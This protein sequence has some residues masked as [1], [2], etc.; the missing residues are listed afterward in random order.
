MR[1]WDFGAIRS[2]TVQPARLRRSYGVASTAAS[3]IGV[4]RYWNHAAAEADEGNRA[5]GSL[6]ALPA[7]LINASDGLGLHI[8]LK[9]HRQCGIKRGR[10]GSCLRKLH[11]HHW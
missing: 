7:N 6:I 11:L 9:S 3:T 5:R 8:G 1:L 4:A 10:S 2:R